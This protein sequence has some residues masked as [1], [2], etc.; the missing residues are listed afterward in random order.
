MGTPPIFSPF[1]FVGYIGLLG[2]VKHLLY[3]FNGTTVYHRFPYDPWNIQTI[4]QNNDELHWTPQM[5]RHSESEF[6]ACFDIFKRCLIKN[7]REIN[8]SWWF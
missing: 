1:A 3:H 4:L 6:S 8:T 5:L 7:I 2:G